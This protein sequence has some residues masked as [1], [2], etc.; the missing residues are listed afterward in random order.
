MN[1][2]ETPEIEKFNENTYIK[3]DSFQKNNGNDQ[4]GK[5]NMNEEEQDKKRNNLINEQNQ[6]NLLLNKI[7]CSKCKENCFVDIIDYKFN[8]YGCK[9]NHK[10]NNI[11][12]ENYEN[13]IP[14]SQIKCNDCK[15][16]IYSNKEYYKCFNCDINICQKCKLKHN[17]EHKVINNNQIDYLCIEHNDKFIK[18]CEDC[19]K[20]ICFHCEI[21]HKE[22]KTIYYG[23]ILPN[24]IDENDKFK[25]CISKLKDDINEIIKRLKY[26]IDNIEIYYKIS[27]NII[28]SNYF[29]N[30]NYQ[31]LKNI[32]EFIKFNNIFINDINNI[33]ND[34]INDKFKKLMTIY[35]KMS[36]INNDNFIMAEINIKEEDINQNIRIINSFE[37]AKRERGISIDNE[38]KNCNEKE[39]MENCEIKINNEIIPFSY[40][41]KFKE[42]GKYIIKYSFNRELTINTCMFSGCEK[43]NKIDLSNFNSKNT[44]YEE[45]ILWM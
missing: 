38:Y 13:T 3:E 35:S 9:N 12:F 22:H 5:I 23:D 15:N 33:N 21:K 19:N 17:K 37:Q 1:G 16:I 32:N 43:I 25:L 26:I 44:Q 10:I 2:P 27:K 4:N 6:D 18:Y 7:I 34:N 42:K 11:L 29:K 8:L 39:I 41:H 45:F 40:F 24:N 36:K 28:N 30:R 20:N 14:I 31:I